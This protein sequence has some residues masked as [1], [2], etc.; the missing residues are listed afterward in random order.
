MVLHNNKWDRKQNRDRIRKLKAKGKE[1]PTASLKTAKDEKKKRN[2]ERDEATDTESDGLAEAEEAEAEEGDKGDESKAAA[3]EEDG[4]FSRRKVTSNAWRYEEESQLP[5]DV[6]DEEPVEDYVALTLSRKG[7]QIKDAEEEAIRKAAIDQ[8]FI[9]ESW[10]RG[11]EVNTKGKVV[12]VDR[13]EFVDVTEKIEKRN[14]A[15]AFRARFEKKTK[16]RAPKTMNEVSSGV[17][18]EADLDAFL[19]ELSLEN[20]ANQPGSIENSGPANRHTSLTT[21]TPHGEEGDD[22]WLDQMLGG[23]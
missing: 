4:V 19:G 3:E 17:G 23:R 11:G 16:A 1:D 12:K 8:A 7:G 5:G 9:N 22:E 15:E 6:P 18:E 20:R 13:R 10:G 21:K 14:N 2:A